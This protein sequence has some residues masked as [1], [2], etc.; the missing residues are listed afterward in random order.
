MVWGRAALPYA[1]HVRGCSE[2]FGL[3]RSRLVGQQAVP[4]PD[5]CWAPHQILL[6]LL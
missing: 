6:E 4:E 2:F 1:C 3:P 5:A